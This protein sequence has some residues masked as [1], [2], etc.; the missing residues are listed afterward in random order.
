MVCR[1]EGSVLKF[2]QLSQRSLNR[3]VCDFTARQ[4]NLTGGADTCKTDRQIKTFR[5]GG[6]V[7]FLVG[8]CIS[9]SLVACHNVSAVTEAV[10]RI[11]WK[12]GSIIAIYFLAAAINSFA[13][14]PLFRSE[15]LGFIRMRRGLL[16]ALLLQ[17]ENCIQDRSSGG[18]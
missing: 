1:G 12:L 3:H 10:Q 9:A 11:G 15:Q 14:L 6:A 18:N 5:F 17:A 7:A 13:W 16:E 2:E 4:T 8:V